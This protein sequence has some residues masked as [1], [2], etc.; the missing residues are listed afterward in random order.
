MC[1]R[2]R[3]IGEDYHLY[4]LA[5]PA[6]KALG[7]NNNAKVTDENIDVALKKIKDCLLYTSWT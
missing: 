7:L 3:T 2:D 4:R 5:N 6:L 1:I